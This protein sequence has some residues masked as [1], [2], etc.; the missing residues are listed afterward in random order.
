VQGH[1][2]YNDKIPTF[3][4]MTALPIKG[5]LLRFACNDEFRLLRASSYRART[6]YL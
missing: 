4:G 5:G 3:V 2:I 6:R 1:G